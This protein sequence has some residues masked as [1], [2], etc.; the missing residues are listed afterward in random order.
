MIKQIMEWTTTV[1][2]IAAAVGLGWV[3]KEVGR[4]SEIAE[5]LPELKVQIAQYEA[6]ALITQ[7][8]Y[9]NMKYVVE[10]CYK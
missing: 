2:S 4:L 1:V 5:E 6:Q 3:L 10:G 7:E 8:R 9:N